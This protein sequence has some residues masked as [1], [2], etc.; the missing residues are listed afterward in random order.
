M[1][2]LIQIQQ[3]NQ[4]IMFGNFTN[5]EL[6]S[7]LDAVRWARAQMAKVKARTFR[8]GDAVKFTDR[9]RGMTYT[10]TVDRVKLKYALVKTA[11]TRFNVPLNMLEEA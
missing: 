2:S 5:D 10:G 4:S 11:T 3:I 8:A 1:Q 6:N 7:V 9:K